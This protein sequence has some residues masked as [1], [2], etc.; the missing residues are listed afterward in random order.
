ME[1]KMVGC[2]WLNSR[3]EANTRCTLGMA[4]PL[5]THVVILGRRVRSPALIFY[6]WCD[7]QQLFLQ[8]QAVKSSNIGSS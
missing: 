2:N 6:S 7:L 8:L 3:Y 4:C 5:Q 1:L